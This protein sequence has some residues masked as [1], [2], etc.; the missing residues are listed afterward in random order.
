VG[1][2]VNLT[3]AAEREQLAR[4]EELMRR[5]PREICEYEDAQRALSADVIVGD[6]HRSWAETVELLASIYEVSRSMAI[7]I[8]YQA[9]RRRQMAFDLTERP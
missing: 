5:H 7:K 9:R 8:L 1:G 4:R 6:T 3:A 2:P